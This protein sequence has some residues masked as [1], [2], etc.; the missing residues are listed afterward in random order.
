VRNIKIKKTLTY[1][2]EPVSVMDHKDCMTWNRVIKF[3]EILWSNHS[4]RDATW[5]QEDY[6]H[7]VYP[8]FYQKW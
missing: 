5:E 8:I 1:V 4:E 7:E 3:Y 2:E 6:L